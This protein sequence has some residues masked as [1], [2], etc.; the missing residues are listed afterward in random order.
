MARADALLSADPTAEVV[1][2]HVDDRFVP[3]CPDE[4]AAALAEDR[5]TFGATA[6][7]LA[8][9]SRAIGD[10]L[11]W[12]LRAFEPALLEAYR[13]FDPDR[14]T[15]S[16]PHRDGT[17]RDADVTEL[18][19]HLH[20][21]LDKA[22]F[23]HLDE[24][25][26]REVVAAAKISGLRVK[27]EPERIAML[28]VWVRGRGEAER[29]CRTWKS[30]VRGIPR[31]CGEFRRLVV[32]ARLKD[33]PH[34]VLKLFKDIPAPDLEALLPHATVQM[35]WLDRLITFGGGG[36]TIGSTAGKLLT[37]VAFTK[38]L[39]VLTVGAGT[40]LVRTVLGYRRRQ[41][42]RDWQ[43]TRHLYFY[44]LANNAG[45]LHSVM[46]MILQEDHKE[47]LLAYAFITANEG[48]FDP[49]RLD[50]QIEAYLQ[51]RFGIHVNFDMTD[52]LATLERLGIFHKDS[53]RLNP[54]AEAVEVLEQYRHTGQVH[55]VPTAPRPQAPQ[56][57]ENAA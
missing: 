38:L 6:G 23:A 8:A 5:A 55:P 42:D 37:A 35:N 56:S 52:A 20:R 28:E 45:V 30:P 44:N 53:G 3:L 17:R 12:D 32:V 34:V 46:R 15:I 33:D 51:E 48:P 11:W 50:R 39:W 26:I 31:R 19:E 54:P 27:L 14:D 7:H 57:V 43:R 22:N 9:I 25:Q 10:A 29:T 1:T 2:H 41:R 24:R 13:P 49:T 4:L 16:L 18:L 40:L 36:V 47:A 21:L